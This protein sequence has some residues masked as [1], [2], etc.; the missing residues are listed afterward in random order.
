MECGVDGEGAVGFFENEN[1]YE[2]EN[3]FG[4]GER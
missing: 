3:D 2:N 1:E 4:V